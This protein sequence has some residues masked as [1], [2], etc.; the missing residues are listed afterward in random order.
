MIHCPN[1]NHGFKKRNLEIYLG[2]KITC[3]TCGSIL[4][5]DMPFGDDH[6]ILIPIEVKNDHVNPVQWTQDG[7]PV[8]TDPAQFQRWEE[9]NRQNLLQEISDVLNAEAVKIAAQAVESRETFIV[10]EIKRL[11][12]QI[13]RVEEDTINK[14]MRVDDELHRLKLSFNRHVGITK[15]I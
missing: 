9:K 15:G 4:K 12:E 7:Y 6:I 1:C 3:D 13:E 8:F 5:I 11:A 2:G 10:E 14:I